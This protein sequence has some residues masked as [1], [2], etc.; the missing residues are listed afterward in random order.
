MKIC[1]INIIFIMF[2]VNILSVIT[3][4]I[5]E[6]NEDYDYADEYEDILQFGLRKYDFLLNF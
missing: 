5:S 2:T 1:V 6:Q 4:A 3:L